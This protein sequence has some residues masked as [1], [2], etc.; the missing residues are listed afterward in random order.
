MTA[1]VTCAEGAPLVRATP[2][3]RAVVRGFEMVSSVGFALNRVDQLVR[4]ATPVSTSSN[5]WLLMARRW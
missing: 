3:T 5:D 2:I 4:A 1:T